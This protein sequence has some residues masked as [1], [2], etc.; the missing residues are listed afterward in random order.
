MVTA[1]GYHPR[2]PSVAFMNMF[3]MEIYYEECKS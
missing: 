1:T 2:T 3:M